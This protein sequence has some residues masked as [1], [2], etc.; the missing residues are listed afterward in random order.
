MHLISLEL[1]LRVKGRVF[2][3]ALSFSR[4]S[5]IDSDTLSVD[6][7]EVEHLDNN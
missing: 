1:S 7:L 4:S 3:I 2:M 5:R 6:D